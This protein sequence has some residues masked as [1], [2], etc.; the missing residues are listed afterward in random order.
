MMTNT[1]KCQLAQAIKIDPADIRDY[2]P[3]RDGGYNVVLMNF[4]KFRNVEPQE[5]EAPEE[6]PRIGTSKARD[7]NIVPGTEIYI[8]ESLQKAYSAPRRAS[9]QVLRQLLDLL[10]V[11]SNSR[12]KKAELVKLVND[13]KAV[14]AP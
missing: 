7:A 13:W 5:E 6:Q 1:L 2:R 11:E 8:P 14:H 3:A 10:E 12:T 9:A 4:Q